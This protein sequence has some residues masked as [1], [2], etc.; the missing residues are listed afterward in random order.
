MN[1]GVLRD[2]PDLRFQDEPDRNLI[3]VKLMRRRDFA[4]AGLFQTMED[5]GVFR[6]GWLN[7]WPFMA[8]EFRHGVMF[9]QIKVERRNGDIALGQQGNVRPFVQVMALDRI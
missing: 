4:N 6:I 9:G 2:K 7:R 5:P 3:H 8:A 1:G